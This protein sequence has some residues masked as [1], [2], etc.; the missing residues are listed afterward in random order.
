MVPPQLKVVILLRTFE[1]DPPEIVLFTTPIF[2][3][4]R[5]LRASTLHFVT[6]YGTFSWSIFKTAETFVKIVVEL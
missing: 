4:P 5:K 1:S 3:N 6:T 2:S